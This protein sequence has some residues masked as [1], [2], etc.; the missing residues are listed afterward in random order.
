[1]KR[2]TGWIFAIA[3]VCV[4]WGAA[5]A[6]SDAAVTAAQVAKWTTRQSADVALVDVRPESRYLGLHVP[7]SMN[8]APFEV[9]AQ[10]CLRKRRI[11]LI[12]DPVGYCATA[13]VRDN[14]VANGFRDVHVLEGGVLSWFPESR[15][16]E[17][18]A[19]NR[20]MLDAALSCK[21]LSPVVVDLRGSGAFEN[22]YLV[23]SVNVPAGK[24]GEES[25][26]RLVARI[27]GAVPDSAGKDPTKPLVLVDDQGP[28]ASWVH[29]L[30]KSR[31]RPYV[32]YLEGGLRQW[33]LS[34]DYPRGTGTISDGGPNVRGCPTCPE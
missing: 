11:V 22:R 3:A 17:V 6:A 16:G 32:F 13:R 8:M 25:E 14:L 34:V 19:V 23:G 20:H 27:E 24:P 28:L 4:L 1:M 18:A 21:A 15:A 9:K 31:E 29:G 7:G 26:S 12:G 5:V 10:D 33:F 2:H 30:V